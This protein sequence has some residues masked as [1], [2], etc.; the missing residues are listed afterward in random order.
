[1]ARL[2][3]IPHVAKTVGPW[4]YLKRIYN[5]SFFEDNLLV[6]AAA[7]AFSWLI[8]LFPFL[9]FALSLV[10]FL[11]ERVKPS[12]Q[13][14]LIWI[15]SAL[16]T[17]ES[18]GEATEEV[19]EETISPEI[20]INDPDKNEPDGVPT[21]MPGDPM[22]ADDDGI[23]NEPLPTTQPGVAATD[24]P[25]V[26]RPPAIISQTITSLVSTLINERPNKLSVF[27]WI[28][29]ALFTASGGVVMTMAGLD[30]CYDVALDK[31]RPWYIN[32]PIAMLLTIILSV[33][34]LLTVI[35]LPI[36]GQVIRFFSEQDL[37]GFE[38]VWLL[39]LTQVLRWA[40]GLLLLL[41]AVSLLYKFGPSVKTRLHLV[42]PGS[43]FTVAMWVLTAVIF[44]FYIESFNAAD[45]YARTY[46][47][48]A[49]VAILM[50]LFYIDALFLLIGAQINAEIDF[51]RLGI[52]SG[53][54]PE[55][56]ETAPIPPYQLDEEDRELKAELE[57]RRSVDIAPESVDASRS[58]S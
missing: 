7:L 18:V 55:E 40:L 13:A 31:I 28:G 12:E 32:R 37:F 47:A 54:L 41:S 53:P 20:E 11:P 49:G 44:Q 3:D 14:I 2:R 19:I 9:I 21:T 50:F 6:W 34:I 5:Q 8:A 45:T 23:R 35:I 29:I 15:E 33:M 36:G 56:Q 26:S 30:E 16:V 17:G 4:T 43:L 57:D 25:P 24:E 39:P 10:P 51:I 46:G 42:S 48:V 38:L 27:L 1:M 58:T 52:K 22:D